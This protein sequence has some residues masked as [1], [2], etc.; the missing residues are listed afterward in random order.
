MKARPAVRHDEHRRA[1]VDCCAMG[2][3][4]EVVWTDEARAELAEEHTWGI[5]LCTGDSTDKLRE[6]IEV[7]LERFRP[8]WERGL[9]KSDD[10][11]SSLIQ[12]ALTAWANGATPATLSVDEAAGVASLLGARSEDHDAPMIELLIRHHGLSF[13]VRVLVRAWSLVTGY[14][15][16]DWPKHENRL[17]IYLRAIDDSSSSVND[18]S[19]SHGKGRMADYLG[20]RHRTGTAAERAELESAVADALPSAPLWARPALARAAQ[21]TTLAEQV[22]R[23]ILDAKP[24]WPQHYA[25]GTLPILI[26]DLELLHRFGYFQ[27][28]GN[29]S[30]RLLERHGIALLPILAARCAAK[31]GPYARKRLAEA[32]V[33]I[34]GPQAAALLA[35]F[36]GKA[37]VKAM[38]KAYFERYPE[39]AP[40]T[41]AAPRKPPA[42]KSPASKPPRRK[43]QR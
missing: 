14:D 43:R 23:E 9:A 1:R 11:G 13:V 22:A 31:P 21:S 6:R 38:V 27:K 32:L 2:Q 17:A 33:H 30:L 35:Q 18:T 4:D 29:I 12:H 42:R 24:S 28:N 36:A 16:P 40:T 39:L 26:G 5:A 7:S 15:D 25:D 10:L 37:P 19:V 3:T 41:T 20:K 34:R 8:C